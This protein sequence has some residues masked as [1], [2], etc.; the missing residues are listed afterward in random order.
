LLLIGLV[1]VTLHLTE[2]EKFAVLVRRARPERASRERNL[3]DERRPKIQKPLA[4]PEESRSE[5]PRVS[6]EGSES[7]PAR[8]RRESPAIPESLMEEVLDRKNLEEAL[9]HQLV[10]RKGAD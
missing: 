9:E 6:R 1:T 7:S 5:A 2:V 8:P 10:D 3:M 4:F